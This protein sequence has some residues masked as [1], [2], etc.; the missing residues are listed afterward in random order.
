MG[1]CPVGNVGGWQGS[2]VAWNWS[3][4]ELPGTWRRCTQIRTPSDTMPRAAGCLTQWRSALSLGGLG[5]A[6]LVGFGARA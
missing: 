1:Y 3:V 6:H 4:S 5:T 2:L